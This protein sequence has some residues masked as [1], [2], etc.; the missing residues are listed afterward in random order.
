MNDSER[1]NYIR[2]IEGYY[3]DN[4]EYV[5]SPTLGDWIVHDETINVEYDKPL[6]NREP[7]TFDATILRLLASE[8]G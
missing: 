5:L 3:N 4:K 2:A 6:R 7:G 1:S 8:E